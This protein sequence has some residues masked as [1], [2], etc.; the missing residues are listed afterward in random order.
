MNTNKTAVKILFLLEELRQLENEF[1]FYSRM[2][3]E[4]P[5]SL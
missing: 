5:D 4:I 1:Y 3:S 2:M